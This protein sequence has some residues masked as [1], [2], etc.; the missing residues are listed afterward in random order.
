M[1]E[2]PRRSVG[3]DSVWRTCDTFSAVRRA[4]V[5]LVASGDALEWVNGSP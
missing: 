3:F 5:D 4:T 1:P 2:A